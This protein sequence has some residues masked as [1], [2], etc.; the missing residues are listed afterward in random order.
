MNGAIALTN[1]WCESPLTSPYSAARRRRRIH[2]QFHSSSNSAVNPSLFILTEKS[3]VEKFC[4][5]LKDEAIQENVFQT[6]SSVYSFVLNFTF[7]V[8]KPIQRICS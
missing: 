5:L 4:A 1:T 6:F 3:K 7:I 8:P 2:V